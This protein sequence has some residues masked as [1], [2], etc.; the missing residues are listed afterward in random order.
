MYGGRKKVGLK[1]KK[2]LYWCSGDA[3]T[4]LK[5]SEIFFFFFFFFRTDA[6][7]EPAICGCLLLLQFGI[8]SATLY[9]DGRKSDA[10]KN[11]FVPEFVGFRSISG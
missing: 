10:K 9:G 11:N 5:K 3:T 1:K 8:A 4:D 7:L 2:T 6:G